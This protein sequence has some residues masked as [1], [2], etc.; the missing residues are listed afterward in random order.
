MNRLVGRGAVFI[1]ILVYWF[2]IHTPIPIMLIPVFGVFAAAVATFSAASLWGV[3]FYLLLRRD[4]DLEKVKGLLKRLRGKKGGIK[5][6]VLGRIPRF[7][8]ES[9]LPLF[10]I[11]VGFVIFGALGGVPIV[12]LTYP[13]KRFHRVLLVILVG[14]ALNVVVWVVLVYGP[15]LLAVRRLFLTL[16]SS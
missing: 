14:C 6:R 10:W 11:L 8:D 1:W 12:K 3:T 13:E 2:T 9:V 16:F 7:E 5:S 4:E 15:P